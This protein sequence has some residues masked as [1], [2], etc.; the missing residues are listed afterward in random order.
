[1]PAPPSVNIARHAEVTGE[2]RSAESEV[3]PGQDQHRKVRC[4]VA[5]DLRERSSRESD[6]AQSR[7]SGGRGDED[8]CR[9]REE[10]TKIGQ[11]IIRI[12]FANE[13][14]PGKVTREFL[15]IPA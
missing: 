1:M 9:V 3:F 8:S 10:M 2:R 15:K 11:E 6:F 4:N 13:D 5:S 12:C 7:A 14:K